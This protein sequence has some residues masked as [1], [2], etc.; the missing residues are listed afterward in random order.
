MDRMDA[1]LWILLPG[2]TAVAAGVL[3][4]F[5]MQSRMEVQ[6]AQERERMTESRGALDAERKAVE[7]SLDTAL[8]AAEATAMREALENFLCELHV[9]QRHYA[10]ESRLLTHSR[11]SLL[12]QERMYFRNIPLSD[13]IEQEITVDDGADVGRLVQDM[14]IFDRSVVA[15]DEAQRIN[16]APRGRKALA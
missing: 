10:R 7:S 3:A 8:Q 2:F 14:T 13:W 1:L 5:V 9:E 11:K 15:I 12:L 4:W 16:E 6:L